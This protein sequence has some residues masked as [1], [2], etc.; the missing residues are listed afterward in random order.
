MSDSL[1]LQNGSDWRSIYNAFEYDL[2]SSEPVEDVSHY[3]SG[4][5]L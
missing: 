1:S 5:F 3:F 2:K 4:L